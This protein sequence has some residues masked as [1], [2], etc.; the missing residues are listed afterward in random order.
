[1][2]L[3]MLTIF[4]TGSGR[5]NFDQSNGIFKIKRYRLFSIPAPGGVGNV[6]LAAAAM[7]ALLK[8]WYIC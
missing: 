1:M 8:N 2:V 5:K 4:G 6:L 3:K 7:D